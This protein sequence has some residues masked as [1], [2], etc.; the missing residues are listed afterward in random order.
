MTIKE[1]RDFLKAQR[2]TGREG[3]LSGVDEDWVRK[4]RSNRKQKMKETERFERKE[5]HKDKT[6]EGNYESSSSS[7]SRWIKVRADLQLR[8]LAE[9]AR[10]S[11]SM[12]KSPQ[13]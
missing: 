11:Y 9:V 2:K 6:A 3:K 8:N 12:Q 5:S 7:S 10:Q 1:D 4:K 13:L